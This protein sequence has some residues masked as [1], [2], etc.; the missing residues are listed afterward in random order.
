[1]AAGARA[2]R[3]PGRR[4]PESRAHGTVPFPRTAAPVGHFLIKLPGLQGRNPAA[5]SSGGRREAAAGWLD[6]RLCDSIAFTAATTVSAGIAKPT[7]M[8]PVESWLA[9][10][11]ATLMPIT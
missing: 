7:P 5:A 2:V 10:A 9:V 3:W 6:Q 11:I 8:L 4:E 1:M